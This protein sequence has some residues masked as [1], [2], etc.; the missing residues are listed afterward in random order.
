MI[1]RAGNASAFPRASHWLAIACGAA[2]HG[3]RRLHAHG[4]RGRQARQVQRRDVKVVA[5]AVVDRAV[6]RYLRRESPFPLLTEESGVVDGGAGDGPRWIVDPL[7]G[8][9]NY[10]RQIPLYAVSI[11]LWIG[12]VPLLGVVHDPVRGGI[13]SGIVARAPG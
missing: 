8:T 13:Y 3:V 2:A 5:D 7:D 11:A 6:I 9:F 4:A 1:A 10:S 12:E